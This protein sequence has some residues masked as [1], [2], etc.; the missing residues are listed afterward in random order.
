MARNDVID[1]ESSGML[2][3][4]AVCV[5][6]IPARPALKTLGRVGRIDSPTSAGSGVGIQIVL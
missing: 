6:G 1:R 5:A 4:P 2:Q 3:H